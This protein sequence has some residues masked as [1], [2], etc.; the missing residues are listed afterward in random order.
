MRSM[1]STMLEATKSTYESSGPLS[2]L[3]VKNHSQKLYSFLLFDGKRN[4]FPIAGC[5]ISEAEL[6]EIQVQVEDV[7]NNCVT[8]ERF[9][10]YMSKAIC[11]QK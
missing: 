8:Q 10:A 9:V 4:F 2:D 11:E 6:Q 5:V 3:W 7:E 1:F